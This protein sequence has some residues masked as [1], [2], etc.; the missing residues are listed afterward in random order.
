MLKVINSVG[1]ICWNDRSSVDDGNK[2]AVALSRLLYKLRIVLRHSLAVA[3]ITVPKEIVDNERMMDK[4]THLCDFSFVLDDSV[5]SVSRLTN[6]TYNGLF[7]LLKLPRLNS[8]MACNTPETLDL[9][10]YVKR[11]RLVVEQLH[12]PPDIGENDDKQKGRTS[13]SSA[14]KIACGSVG[15]GSGSNCDF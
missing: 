11:K 2:S 1:S 15:A 8:M 5:K 6:T 12:L 4:L 14:V 9:A 10:F 3:L 13:T 7:R